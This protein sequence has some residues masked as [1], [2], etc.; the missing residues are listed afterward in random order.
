MCLFFLQADLL[1]PESIPPSLVGIHTI[2]DC[3]TARPEESIQ[4]ID[5]EGKMA[6]I[7]TA[8]AMGIERYVFLSIEG[9]QKH[10]D[11]PLM[12]M[13]RCTEQY[14]EQIGLPYTT[15]RLCGFMQVIAGMVIRNLHG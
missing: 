7:Q 12:D 5:W 13:K 1:K 2:I 3:A 9:C 8:K 6:L 10:P 14:L 11:V 4:K 15:L